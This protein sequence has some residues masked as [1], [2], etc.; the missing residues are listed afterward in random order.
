M[1]QSRLAYQNSQIAL[2]RSA[3]VPFKKQKP[4]PFEH[5]HYK[6]NQRAYKASFFQR[7]SVLKITNLTVT[8]SVPKQQSCRNTEQSIAIL[9][10]TSPIVINVPTRGLLVALTKDSF[11][12]WLAKFQY[13]KSC[14]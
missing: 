4:K 7:A 2:T 10:V 3:S 8:A 13:Q 14:L 11:V 6:L 9:T 1:P 12:L 5:N